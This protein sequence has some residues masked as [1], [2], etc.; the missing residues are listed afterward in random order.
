[1]APA[2]TVSLRTAFPAKAAAPA[3]PRATASGRTTTRRVHERE[4]VDEIRSFLRDA[5]RDQTPH[6]FSEKGDGC[7]LKRVFRGLQ[8]LAHDPHELVETGAVAH[9]DVQ[10]RELEIFGKALELRGR[11]ETG[12]VQTR[13]VHHARLRLGVRGRPRNP[14]RD[15]VNNRG[16]EPGRPAGL[17]REQV[18]QSHALCLASA[19]SRDALHEGVLARGAGRRTRRTPR[20]PLVWK[21]ARRRP[22]RTRARKARRRPRDSRPRAPSRYL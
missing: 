21:A 1:M 4:R 19:L 16:E 9:R 2:R 6:G 11:R 3:R 17:S 22:W 20:R 14:R 18:V 10:A 13:D 8:V 15:E 12:A 7:V 5:E